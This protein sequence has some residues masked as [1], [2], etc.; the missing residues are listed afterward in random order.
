MEETYGAFA[1]VYDDC[2]EEI[3]Y[4][5]WFLYIHHFLEQYGVKPGALVLEL[6]CGTGTF[7]MRMKQ[8][9]FDM[10]GIDASYDML[11]IARDKMYEAELSDIL[12]L[13][14]DMREFELYGTV[15]AIVSVCDTMNYLNSYEEL[16]QVLRLA[17][18]YLDPGGIFIFDLKT[19]YYFQNRVGNQT[20]SDV[21]EDGAIFWENEYD[22]TTKENVYRV[23]MF[24]QQDEET[25]LYRREEEVHV[26]RAFSLEELQRG[27]AEAGLRLVGVFDGVSFEPGVTKE[28]ERYYVIAQECTK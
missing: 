21:F 27:V 22:E 4:E 19:E 16:V 20:F 9:G 18:N 8:A 2:M 23:T 14:Q 12:Y 1:S 15:E 13:Q 28:C 25:A 7:T 26:Q 24:L 6:G 10:I 3:P 17:N 5:E 11:N